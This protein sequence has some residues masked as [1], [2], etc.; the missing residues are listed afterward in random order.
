M[1]INLLLFSFKNFN[2]KSNNKPNKSINNQTQNLDLFD[3]YNALLNR[4]LI[5]FKGKEK[6]FSSEI[7]KLI[8]KGD[9]NELFEY[10]SSQLRKKAQEKKIDT[11]IIDD[12]VQNAIVEILLLFQDFSDDKLSKKELLD[13]INEIYEKIKPK[14]GDYVSDFKTVSLETPILDGDKILADTIADD[15][16]HRISYLSNPDDETKEKF[17]KLASLALDGVELD[18]REKDVLS[19]RFNNERK[20]TF[21][22]IANRHEIAITTMFLAFKR[23]I[24]KIQVKNNSLPEDIKQNILDTV[25]LFKDEGLTYEQYLEACLAQP[26][27]FIQLPKDTEK[28]VRDLVEK[29][30]KEGLTVKDYLNKACLKQ[31]QLFYQSPN[32]VEKKVRDL[33]EKFK[34]KV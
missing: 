15:K 34:K 18:D 22:T 25:E 8:E 11:N 13:K 5:N 28:K 32:T 26:Y 7:E 33:V 17:K 24:Y 1:R 10:I 19:G 29:F 31:P 9:E 23:V 2:I 14:K 21:Q 30:E 4:T 12:V 16:K 27:L 6:S 20:E 3:S